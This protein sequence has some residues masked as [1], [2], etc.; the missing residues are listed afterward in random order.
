MNNEKR[1]PIFKD[2]LL[3]GT[4]LNENHGCASLLQ[5]VYSKRCSAA[6]NVVQLVLRHN[7]FRNLE[8]S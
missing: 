7:S 5:V 6:R 2:S 1:K 3:L 4:K 8:A